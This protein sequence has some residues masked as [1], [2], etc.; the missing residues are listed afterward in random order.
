V[1]EKYRKI[2]K[3]RI[4]AVGISFCIIA[5]YLLLGRINFFEYSSVD[6]QQDYYA[7]K[8][9]LNHE[10][11]YSD[12]LYINNHPPATAIILVPLSFFPYKVAGIIWTLL[13]IVLYLY[14]GWLVINELNLHLPIEYIF[15][16]IGF[17]LCWHPFLIHIGQGQ[18]SI[19]IGFCLAVCWISLRHDRNILA[20]VVLGLACLIKLF[21]GLL[22]LY[23]LFTK[24]L[25]AMV[26]TLLVIIFGTIITGIIVNPKDIIYYFTTVISYDT[27]M[28]SIT[29]TNYSASGILS[30][31]FSNSYGNWVTPIFISPIPIH[32][33]TLIVDI[34]LIFYLLIILRRHQNN[35][36]Y[37]DIIFS[38]FI[39]SMLF[40][41]PVSW[42]H[43]L[44]VLILPVFIIY[45]NMKN[46]TL[47]S[48]Y[49]YSLAI[50]GLILLS[51]P[52]IQ[53][54]IFLIGLT[55]PDRL[56]WYFGIGF[57]YYDVGLVILYWLLLRSRKVEQI[58]Q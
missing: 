16:V 25:K 46:R 56:P 55:F 10:S 19:L 39:I 54:D 18:W 31:F 33:L 57:L 22:L 14:T 27:N 30:K 34:I 36:N 41:S 5:I 20:G 37:K 15:V 6:L 42:Q 13:S 49:V 35:Q 50:L 40:I 48:K 51:I 21:P 4:L 1:Q 3:G 52:D 26:T 44:T 47:G 8:H 17:G 53:F 45:S 43:S 32:W 7:A 12:E 29:P 2:K 11:I 23:M 9:I 28:Y 58:I 24:R 38:L